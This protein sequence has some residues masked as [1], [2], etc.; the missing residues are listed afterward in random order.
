METDY[1]KYRGK[2]K[3]YV[4]NAIKKNPSLTAV[5]GYYDCPLFG[6]QQHWWCIDV[7]GNIVDPTVKQFPSK[8]LGEY[9]PYDGNITCDQCGKV[10]PE[11]E[12]HFNG[13]YA[14]CSYSCAMHFVGL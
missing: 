6:R 5:R 3:E 10:V 7:K 1:Q 12:A 11:S 9:I 8:G 4:E 13:N 14:F 2:C